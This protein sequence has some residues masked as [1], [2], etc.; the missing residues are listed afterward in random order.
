[1]Q[2]Y[3]RVM[4]EDTCCTC[5]VRHVGHIGFNDSKLLIQR[6]LFPSLLSS[7]FLCQKTSSFTAVVFV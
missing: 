6:R 7:L 2:A 3:E 4:E 1:M 5:V